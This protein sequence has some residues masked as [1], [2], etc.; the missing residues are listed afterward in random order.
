MKSYFILKEKHKE[1]LKITSLRITYNM[2]YH[3]YP[4]LTNFSISALPSLY[5]FVSFFLNLH[6]YFAVHIFLEPSTGL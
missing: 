2:L 4:H 3:I 6:W 1:F 5:T